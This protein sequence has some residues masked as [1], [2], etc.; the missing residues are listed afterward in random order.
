MH[1]WWVAPSSNIASKHL[2]NNP[3]PTSMASLGLSSQARCAVA[4]QLCGRIIDEDDTYD[5]DVSFEAEPEFHDETVED[6]F[7]DT[8]PPD[9]ESTGQ[10]VQ[11]TGLLKL[12]NDDL[13]HNKQPWYNTYVSSGTDGLSREVM[14]EVTE[15]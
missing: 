8:G 15:E 6:E 1:L 12:V 5:S 14:E 13:H 10:D 2:T 7:D 3:T 4:N 9:N 11:S